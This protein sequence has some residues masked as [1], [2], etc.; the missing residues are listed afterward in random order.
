[1]RFFRVLLP[2]LFVRN[3]YTGEW[4]FSRTRMGIFVALLIL[5]GAGIVTIIELQAPV[6]YA[7][8]T[9]AAK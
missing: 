9:H 3:W 5:F 7:A 2:F 4:E 6:E 1:M 8:P